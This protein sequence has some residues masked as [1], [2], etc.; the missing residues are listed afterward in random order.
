MLSENGPAGRCGNGAAPTPLGLR[1][2]QIMSWLIVVALTLLSTVLF[3]ALLACVEAGYRVGRRRIERNPDVVAGAGVIEAAVFGLMGLLLAFQFAAAQNRLE[4]RRSL[5][6][7]EANAIGTAYLR[8]DLL[9]A[10]DRPPLRDMF[11]R[12]TDSRI[13]AFDA[14]PDT[15]LYERKLAEANRLQG[16]I[17]STATAAALNDP[18]PATRQ[19][20]IPPI[21]DMI[22]ITTDRTVATM[23]H[24]PTAIVT[25]LVLVALTG[26]VLAGHAM[27][28]RRKGHSTMH[29]VIF[30]VVVTATL[31]VMVDLEFPRYGLIRN[32]DADQALHNTRAGMN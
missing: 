12:Y 15:I 26:A 27:A 31:Y 16:Q 28:V 17:W 7:R 20:V 8:L 2:E 24:V 4:F 32:D 13:A 21:N 5:I 22:D 29:E 10:S 19:L 11:R 14:L 6:V 3:A 1:T 30:A 9:P 25:L 18:N 23:N